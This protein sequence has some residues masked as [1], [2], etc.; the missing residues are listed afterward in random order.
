MHTPRARASHLR[1][2]I[3]FA[4]DNMYSHYA[5][6][7]LHLA[8][9][10]ILKYRASTPPYYPLPWC[11]RPWFINFYARELIWEGRYYQCVHLQEWCCRWVVN[12]RCCCVAAG[13]SLKPRGL[14]VCGV[15]CCSFSRTF[16]LAADIERGKVW[17]PDVIVKPE[18]FRFWI[19]YSQC[20][21]L[22][23]E[24]PNSRNGRC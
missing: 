4:Y 9:L 20:R 23:S 11:T 17:Q 18:R 1:T 22:S 8:C 13:D 3:P 12:Q 24:G 2:L 14:I 6:V 16:R 21:C 5:R 15:C 10:I 19:K 7:A